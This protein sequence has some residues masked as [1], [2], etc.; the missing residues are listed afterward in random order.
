MYVC[1]CFGV[2]ESDVTDAA[3][4]GHDTPRK[5]AAA[6]GGAGT[7]CGSCVRRIQALLGRAPADGPAAPRPTAGV[8]R[9][10]VVVSQEA[11]APAVA[12]PALVAAAPAAPATAAP[13]VL[14]AVR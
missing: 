2:T 11:S 12:V 8:R 13:A 3:C 6:C 14:A 9:R 4:Q 5:I 7:D 1:M 10:P